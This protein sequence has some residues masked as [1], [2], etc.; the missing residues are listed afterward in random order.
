MSSSAKSQEKAIEILTQ[1]ERS[2]QKD[3]TFLDGKR[4]S[5]LDIALAAI[6]YPW[7][8]DSAERKAHFSGGQDH[9]AITNAPVPPVVSKMSEEFAK[10]FPK[11]HWQCLR[12]YEEH[13]M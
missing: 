6:N 8:L 10:Q 5:R 1:F 12:M 2:L 7:A 4:P 9:G 11:V 3:A 13:R